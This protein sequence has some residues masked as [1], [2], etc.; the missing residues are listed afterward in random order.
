MWCGFLVLVSVG[1]L[2]TVILYIAAKAGIF[3]YFLLSTVLLYVSIT[4]RALARDGMEIYN[5]L[6]KEM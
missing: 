6:K 2:S 5:L 3:C 1:I 4:P